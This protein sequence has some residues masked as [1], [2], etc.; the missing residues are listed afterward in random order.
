MHCARVIRRRYRD[1]NQEPIDRVARRSS[2]FRYCTNTIHQEFVYRFNSAIATL[3]LCTSSG[4]S[5]S[6]SVLNVAYE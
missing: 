6:L 1:L 2:S 3:C 4:P 5:A